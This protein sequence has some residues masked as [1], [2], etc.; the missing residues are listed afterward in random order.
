MAVDNQARLKYY[1]KEDTNQILVSGS[2]TVASTNAMITSS[3]NPITQGSTF[4]NSKIVNFGV[5]TSYMVENGPEFT[6]LNYTQVLNNF[7]SVYVDNQIGTSPTNITGDKF[8]TGATVTLTASPVTL[9]GDVSTFQILQIFVVNTGSGWQ[10]GETFTIPQSVLIGK[11]FNNPTADLVVT[12]GSN[13][14]NKYG[15]EIPLKA[16]QELWVHRGYS[17]VGGDFSDESRNNPYRY[18]PHLH[19]AYKAYIV[20]ETG[21]GNPVNPWFPIGEPIDTGLTSVNIFGLETQD[22]NIPDA[23][24]EKQLAIIGNESVPGGGEDNDLSPIAI[25][26][27]FQIFDPSRKVHPWVWTKYTTLSNPP[28]GGAAWRLYQESASISFDNFEFSTATPPYPPGSDKITFNSANASTNNKV[29]VS[30]TGATYTPSINI[31]QLSESYARGKTGAVIKFA[32]AGLGVGNSV[33]YDLDS[34]E[35]ELNYWTMN[36]SN[37]T[38]TPGSFTTF[39]NNTPLDFEFVSYPKNVGQIQQSQFTTFN[40]QPE[41]FNSIKLFNPG[42]YSYTSSNFI[43]IAE[44]GSPASGSTQF[45]LYADLDYYASYKASVSALYSDTVRVFYTSSNNT[46]SYFDLDP[47]S[48]SIFPALVGTLTQSGYTPTGF[49]PTTMAI[50]GTY[51]GEEFDITLTAN[52]ATGIPTPPPDIFAKRWESAYISYSSSLSSSLDGLYVFNQL[53]QNDIQVTASMFLNAWTGSSPGAR[54]G[55]NTSEYGTTVYDEGEAG[56]GPT[57]PTASIRIYTGSYPTAVPSTLDAFVTQSE[58]RD[59]N[60]HINGLAITMSYL[61]PSQSISIK[62]CLSLALAVSSGSANSASVEN[63]LV[64]REYYLEFNTPTSSL[65]GDGLVPTFIE[66]AYEGTDGFSN[67][68]DCQPLLNNVVGERRNKFFQEVDYTT[69]IYDPINFQA[70]LSGSAQKST[71]PLSNYTTFAITNPRFRGS[72]TSANNVNSVEGL[73]NG[74]GTLPVIDYKTAYFAYCDQILDPY[75]VINNVTQFNIKYLINEQ[76]DALQPNASPYTALDVEG[77]WTA[78]KQG[79]VAVNQISGSSQFDVLNGL[80]D[81]KKVAQE[82]VAVL[83]SQTGANTTASAI[84][85]AGAPGTVSTYVS[86]FLSYGMSVAGRNTDNNNLNDKNIPTY[87]ILS[88]ID[89]NNLFT[90][91]TS[92]RY[93]KVAAG[94]ENQASSSI[95]S[96]LSPAP[97]PE[98]NNN[99]NV[100]YASPGEFYFNEDYF[101]INGSGDTP[102]GYDYLSGNQLSDVYS[103]SVLAE[104]PSSVPQEVRT[105][106]GGWN[107]SSDYN[108][109]N[110]GNISMKLQRRRTNFPYSWTSLQMEQL[111]PPI[112]RLYFSGGQTLDVDL[113]ASFGSNNAGLR[114]NGTECYVQINPQ[115]LGN[116]VTQAGLSKNNA[117]YVSYIFNLKSANSVT[118]QADRRYRWVA[119]QFYGSENID[120]ERNYYNPT[121]KAQ[122]LGSLPT[123][124]RAQ[125]GPYIT[126]NVRGVSEVSS[127]VDGALNAPYWGFLAGDQTILELL[128]ENGNVTYGGEYYQTYLPYTASANPLFPGG[129]EPIDTTI[130]AYNIPWVL[131]TGDEIRF[132]NNE[133]EVYKILEVIPP[134]QT[135]ANK[136]QV[137]L[138]REVP[139]NIQKD[140]FL[141]RRYRRSPNTIVVDSLFPYGGLITDQ[142]QIDNTLTTGVTNFL[143]GQDDVDP[144]VAEPGNGAYYTSSL[145]QTTSGSIEFRSIERPL[146]KKDNTPSGLFLPEFPTKRIETE[147]DSI[148]KQLRD[149]KLLT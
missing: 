20:V 138:D 40:N 120:A 106:E 57:W 35:N 80:N 97:N 84:P 46:S 33:Q 69:G 64:V 86:E 144:P 104:F 146:S 92:S 13:E 124:I 142:V 63:S 50:D 3:K 11:G 134:D 25:S 137:V 9:P 6:S 148:I 61:I 75:P 73:V 31:A 1:F 115:A 87:N 91:T 54:Y 136:L 81:I 133:N 76:G 36:V 111:A 128:S 116:T 95:V 39:P 96:I 117:V 107:D 5:D 37:P 72:E 108:R 27:S 60:I 8:G 10:A 129:L 2:D 131:L 126:A 68:P 71:V 105:D 38:V 18:N 48:Q 28:I 43:T 49:D 24:L 83:W 26:G 93:G 14:I 45:G 130:P 122:N 143:D 29:F 70:I 74:F 55:A 34:I 88:E 41:T 22:F 119:N 4:Y 56:D 42:I 44:N 65:E 121:T 145:D 99:S 19:R 59:E 32:D 125:R 17:T 139:A 140:F 67:S 149:N 79:V 15:T 78:G 132:Q 52:S 109:T 12:L 112:M 23:F 85:V 30:K 100:S 21:S 102:P 101:A 77:S 16:D 135:S 123:P 7:T 110:V 82:P 90:F 53:P 127:N 51:N 113:A 98:I 103:L 66:N 47:G 147:P 89:S 118:L 58:F 62:D 141:I 94:T 114:N